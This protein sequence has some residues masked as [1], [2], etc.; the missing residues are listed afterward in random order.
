MFSDQA[1]H[2]PSLPVLILGQPRQPSFGLGQFR[3]KP[4]CSRA[5]TVRPV[6]NPSLLVSRAVLSCRFQVSQVGQAPAAIGLLLGEDRRQQGRALGA[7]SRDRAAL[8]K[9]IEDKSY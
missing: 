7:R 2:N 3:A 9:P 6:A 8:R 1:G 4:D 5:R